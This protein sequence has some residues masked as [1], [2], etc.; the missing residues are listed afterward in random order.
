MQVVV[1]LN[2]LANAVGGVVFAPIAAM[3]GWLS[4]TIIGAATG[5]LMLVAYKY[6]SN[7]DAIQRVRDEI[8]AHLLSLKLFKDNMRVVFRA[9]GQI[10]WG[11]L[12]LITLSIAPMLVMLVPIVLIMTQLSL[13]Y[14]ARPFH[15]DEIATVKVYL[16]GEPADPL[17]DV[18]LAPV[19]G[20]EVDTPVHAPGGRFVAWNLRPK[21]NAY[22]RLAFEVDGKSYEKELAVGDGLMRV[23]KLRPDSSFEDVLLNP[24]ERPFGPDSPVQSILIQYKDRD[25]YTSGTTWW[26][27]YWFAV[28]MVAA[29]ILHKPLGVK[30]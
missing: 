9:Q 12:R 29:L 7:Q 27:V 25:S 20:V 5:V 2:D 30:L 8:K 10:I 23:S 17:P 19:D 26:V 18:T 4:A 21:Q 15:V 16:S 11:A 28:S 6:T 1:W 14:Q 24:A 3:P 13:W 22:H